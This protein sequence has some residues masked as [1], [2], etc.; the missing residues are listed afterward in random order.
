MHSPPSFVC[1]NENR[2]QNIR[3]LL[4]ALNRCNKEHL[5]AFCYLQN[6]TGYGAL[7]LKFMLQLCMLYV[8]QVKIRTYICKPD[9]TTSSYSWICCNIISLSQ[10]RVPIQFQELLYPQQFFI[11]NYYI[12]GDVTTIS[13]W[14]LPRQPS[15][16]T[17]ML[18]LPIISQIEVCHAL[19]PLFV[20][21]I[22]VFVISFYLSSF[23][24]GSL[25]FVLVEHCAVFIYVCWEHSCTKLCHLVKFDL[26]TNWVNN[27]YS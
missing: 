22:I 27:P 21:L 1:N 7:I 5:E 10:L 2:H 15:S 26:L 20:P 12:P 24:I 14:I 9:S 16:D 3:R 8:R 11:L 17:Q 25:W 19:Y 13:L 23:C 4:V 6:K 18:T